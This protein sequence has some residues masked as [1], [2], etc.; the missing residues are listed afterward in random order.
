MVSF[1]YP[2]KSIIQ[3]LYPSINSNNRDSCI[4]K[5]FFT[6]PL[7]FIFTFNCFRNKIWSNTGANATLA[8]LSLLFLF[9]RKTRTM[10]ST[11]IIT[12]VLFFVPSPS[13]FY[14]TRI[15]SRTSSRWLLRVWNLARFQN[16]HNN[17]DLQRECSI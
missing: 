13:F 8:Y 15:F 17:S 1:D 4:S 16:D 7:C 9:S 6:R 3:I 12:G 2:E 14:D 10:L 5:F 11:Q